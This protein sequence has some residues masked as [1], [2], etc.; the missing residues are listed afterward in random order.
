MFRYLHRPETDDAI[1]LIRA[2]EYFEM[3]NVTRFA[4]LTLLVFVFVT[5]VQLL[6]HFV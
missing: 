3:V 1:V 5:E 4:H 2:G 6:R